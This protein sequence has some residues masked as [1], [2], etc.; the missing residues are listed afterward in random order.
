MALVERLKALRVYL[1]GREFNVY[2]DHESLKYLMKARYHR[3]KLM[4]WAIEIQEYNIKDIVH[5]P[6]T[7]NNIPDA[8]SRL[9]LRDFLEIT[10]SKD[11]DFLF[12]SNVVNGFDGVDEGTED[13]YVVPNEDA[14][15]SFVLTPAALSAM[16]EKQ[17]KD[18]YLGS[19]IAYLEN[20]LP[21]DSPYQ[22][23]FKR[24]AEKFTLWKGRLYFHTI[25]RDGTIFRRLTIPE[26]IKQE[27]LTD[28]HEKSGHQG[29]QRTYEFI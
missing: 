27:I 9:P 1:M 22:K 4:R 12:S 26:V 3:V 28:L 8:L 5:I 21:I 25:K 20:K 7:T 13:G 6:G 14:I 19:I 15:S 16:A 29:I 24:F 23:H 2:M 10:E 17:R 18:E 11:E